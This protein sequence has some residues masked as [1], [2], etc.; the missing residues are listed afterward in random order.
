MD[1]FNTYCI[2]EAQD[3]LVRIKAELVVDTATYWELQQRLSGTYDS[4]YFEEQYKDMMK[5]FS[6]LSAINCGHNLIKSIKADIQKMEAEDAI[7]RDAQLD[8]QG[9]KHEEWLED[10]MSA[11]RDMFNT[12]RSK[13]VSI[14]AWKD[15]EF[16]DEHHYVV[17]AQNHKLEFVTW[18]WANGGF[19]DG[20]YYSDNELKAWANYKGRT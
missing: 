17:M 8:A 3:N 4:G 10:S 11:Q 1:T 12:A 16:H 2:N 20:H 5:Q 13:G 9:L 6:A 15:T 7:Q 19:H 18:V 14:M